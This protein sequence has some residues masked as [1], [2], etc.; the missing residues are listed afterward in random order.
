MIKI[1]YLMFLIFFRRC[2]HV[3]NSIIY[4]LL[5]FFA[6]RAIFSRYR[7]FVLENFQLKGLFDCSNNK[8]L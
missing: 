8:E 5:F 4:D 2:I 1:Y 7:D 3:R 6:L